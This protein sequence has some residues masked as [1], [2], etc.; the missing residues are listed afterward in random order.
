LGYFQTL[1]E[2]EIFNERKNKFL[3]IGRGKGFMTNPGDLSSL[4]VQESKFDKIMKS[5]KII[6]PIIISLVLIISLYLVL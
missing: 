1:S 4:Q 2:S 6:V 5:K 3:K